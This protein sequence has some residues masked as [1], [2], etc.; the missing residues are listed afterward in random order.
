MIR[1]LR[2][3]AW[4]RWRLF[5]NGLRGR[6]RDSLEQVSRAARLLVLAILVVALLPGSILLGVLAFTGGRGMALGE[7]HAA[8][9]LIGARGV[10]AVVLI[11]V[12]ISPIL[13][14]GGAAQSMT[15]LALLPIP[16]RALFVTEIASHLADPWILVIVPALLSLPAGL[17]AEGAFRAAA[18]ALVLGMLALVV[19]AAAGSM[20]ALLGALV[21]RHRRLGEMASVGLLVGMT[22]LAYVPIL[23]SHGADALGAP[24][25]L[26]L[27]AHPWLAAMPWEL[28]A[29]GL[30]AGLERVPWGTLAGLAATAAVFTL[31]GALAFA[32]IMS[33]PGDR[34]SRAKRREERL[35]RIPGLSPAS[36]AVA[37]AF[38]RLV[39]RS[40]R[41]RII[42]FTAPLPSFLFGFLWRGRSMGLVDPAYT[43]LLV[44]AGAALLTL[45][46]M[47]PFQSDQFAVDRA[48]LTLTFLTPI[49]GNEIVVG[50]A[51]AALGAFA[52]PVAGGLT[53]A[54]VLYPHGSPVVWLGAILC[55]FAAF[56]AQSPV[57]AFIAAVLPAPFDLTRLR[58]G[59]P[60]PLASIVTS[61]VSVIAFAACAGVFTSALALTGSRWGGLAAA[62]A[63]FAAAAAI[64]RA[65][66]PLA[67]RALDARRENLAMMAQGR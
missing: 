36:S 46:S 38:F 47:T 59:N 27:E 12:L 42:L 61:L 50:K 39:T 40:V 37:R 44:V 5:V 26:D 32:R 23:R 43:G 63:V 3:F 17:A 33:A 10:L 49:S 20:S 14:F 8:A 58:G 60:H 52:M 7:P 24:I 21:F 51:A 65:G 64:A 35:R 16:R 4:L 55:V 25:R 48:G 2:A 66:W 22:L 54:I 53:I 1:S 28:Y 31:A 13:R 67:G 34:R 41:G 9:L 45:I 19:L 18:S 6:R 11:V 15:R 57:A 29:R 56:L 62:I 30:E